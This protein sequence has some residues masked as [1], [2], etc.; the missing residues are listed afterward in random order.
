MIIAKNKLLNLEEKTVGAQ[1]QLPLAVLQLPED[2]ATV[3]ALDDP[4]QGG[5][6]VQ[7]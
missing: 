1:A 2:R 6:V 7:G 5:N 4:R 3:H